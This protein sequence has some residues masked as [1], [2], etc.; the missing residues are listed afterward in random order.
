MTPQGAERMP[1]FRCESCCCG[2]A[3]VLHPPRGVT[4]ICAT[5][6]NPLTRQ[7]LVRPL[8][9]LVLLMIGSVLILSSVPVLRDSRP[10]PPPPSPSQPM[11]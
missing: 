4:P 9:L 11:A 6:G 7:P 8:G 10:K 1:R 3:T 2:P 5:C